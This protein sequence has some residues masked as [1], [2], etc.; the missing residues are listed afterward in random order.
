MCLA[1]FTGRWEYVRDI[2]LND[3]SKCL[4]GEYKLNKAVKGIHHCQTKK[5]FQSHGTDMEKN[6]P[7]NMSNFLAHSAVVRVLLLSLLKSFGKKF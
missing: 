4:R 1:R 7:S 2:R 5:K 3:N 6:L